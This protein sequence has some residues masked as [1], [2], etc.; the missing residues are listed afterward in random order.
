VAA[1]K[2][3]F[4]RSA[5]NYDVDQASD[6]A[7]IKCPESMAQQQ[8]K[9]E[10]DINTIVDRFGLTGEMP[11]NFRMPVSGDFTGITDFH[12]AMNTVR[13]AEEAFMSVPAEL[14]AEFNNDPGRL[15]AFVE[16]DKNRARAIE[17]GLVP[18]PP[19]VDRSGA[20]VLREGDPVPQPSP[21]VKTAT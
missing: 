16:D 4:L 1:G 19:E 17:L 20:P 21:S 5:F 15:M 12:S 6:E 13:Q 10:V 7:G 9:E 11:E 2:V 18:K 8:F 3:I 14:R